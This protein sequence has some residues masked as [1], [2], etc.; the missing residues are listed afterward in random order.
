MSNSTQRD[1][2]YWEIIKDKFGKAVDPRTGGAGQAHRQTQDHMNDLDK[3]NEE[4][5]NTSPQDTKNI[6]K[7]FEK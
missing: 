4:L 2:S 1:S 6:K 3:I 7:I 5:N